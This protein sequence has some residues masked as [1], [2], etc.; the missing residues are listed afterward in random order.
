MNYAQA[1]HKKIKDE[2]KVI[3]SRWKIFARL[4]K[5]EIDLS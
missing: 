3:Y 2:G 5:E 4:G 1:Q